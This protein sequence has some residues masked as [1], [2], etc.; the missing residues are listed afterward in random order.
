MN[1]FILPNESKNSQTSNG[2]PMTHDT[3]HR[4]ENEFYAIFNLRSIERKIEREQCMIV[5]CTVVINIMS[6][7]GVDRHMRCLCR[8]L[9]RIPFAGWFYHLQI[10]SSHIHSY[11][12]CALCTLRYMFYRNLI[13]YSFFRSVLLFCMKLKFADEKNRKK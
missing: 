9:D 5:H 12:G 7:G 6:T 1:A 2:S 10:H 3:V 11:T 13:S 8:Q 4:I